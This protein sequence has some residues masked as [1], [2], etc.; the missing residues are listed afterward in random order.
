LL[1]IR[2]DWNIRVDPQGYCAQMGVELQRLRRKAG[3]EEML[4]QAATELEQVMRPAACWESFPVRA[5]RHEKLVLEG[6]VCLEGELVARMLGGAE[7]AIAAVMT[8]GGGVDRAILAAQQQGAYLKAMLLH[9]LATMAVDTLRQEVCSQIERGAAQA[10]LL[11][12]PPISPGEARWTMDGQRAIFSLLDAGQ[13][14]VTLTESLVMVPIKSLSM[15][16]GSGTQAMG[17][18]EA[19]AC[20]IC[21]I[22][23]RC[24]Y[25]ARRSAAA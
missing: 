13:I 4:S 9:D 21:T 7:R 6:G 19:D 1:V 14:G 11:T 3:W 5:I 8:L 16:I 22:Q 23:E 2:N 24:R 17:Q 25:R 10:G 18:T 20:A 15:V 12:S